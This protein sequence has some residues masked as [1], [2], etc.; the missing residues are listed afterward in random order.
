MEMPF[1]DV[2]SSGNRYHKPSV[3]LVILG[4]HTVDSVGIL[5]GRS[6]YNPASYAL[7]GKEHPAICGC[8][9]RILT[10][11]IWFGENTR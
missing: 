8:A 4:R 10:V 1:T 2:F 3:R 9:T 5:F 6:T 11:S 7:S